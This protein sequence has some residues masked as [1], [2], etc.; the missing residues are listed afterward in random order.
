[1]PPDPR[2]ARIAAVDFRV[3]HVSAKTNWSFVSVRMEDGV[4]GVGEASLNGYEPL[5]AAYLGLLGPRLVGVQPDDALPALATSA[6][7]PAGLVANAVR[8]AVRQAFVDARAKALGVP[9][10]QVLGGK[11]RERVPVY[12]NV[13]RATAD[14]S[15]SGCAA[16]ARAA[17][18]QGFRA[19]KIAPFDGVLPD[20]LAHP[21]TQRAIDA[22][23]ERVRAMREAVGPDVRL[24]V[25]CHWRFDEPTA[26]HVLDRL[27][28]LAVQ[29]FEC[30]VSEQ[31][32]AHDAL[33]RIRA[34]AQ[35]R[36]IVVAACEL[37]T[38][39]DGFRP[40]VERRRVDA[41]MPD[42]KYCGGPIEMLR[43]AKHA[44]AHGVAFSPHN[45]TGP[46]CTLASLHAALAAVAVESL[47]LQVG[48]SDLSR[49]IVRGVEPALA[50]SAFAAPDA[51]GWGVEL[52]EAVLDAHPYRQVPA[53][54]DE[55]LG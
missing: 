54:L 36:G 9:A 45:P 34:A 47:E 41:I 23:V 39:V 29:W 14:R 26:L 21:S 2:P 37:Q 24:M 15:P 33:A 52:D 48:E 1:V 49:A 43:I 51:P 27:A 31:P 40:F 6:N 28:G 44:Q 5:L 4:K 16:S 32:H 3:L 55:R 13:N 53:G 8:S 20:A 46:V 35:E 7:A 22:G 12:A 25:D 42:V 38:G 18:E 11:R 19:V 17:V 10:W 50:G 30:P